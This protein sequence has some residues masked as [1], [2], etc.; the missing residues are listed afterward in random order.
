MDKLC[1]FSDEMGLYGC[2]EYLHKIQGL[3]LIDNV[4]DLIRVYVF[5]SLDNRSKICCIVEGSSIRFQDHAGRNLDLVVRLRDV[6]DQ[7]SL[8]VVSITFRF[9]LL[10]HRSD[11]RLYCGF[12]VPQIEGDIQSFVVLLQVCHRQFHDLKPHSAVARSSHL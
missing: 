7:G 11:I 1:I 3:A 12:T 9:Q 6:D 8:I 10:Y 5:H 4:N 2:P